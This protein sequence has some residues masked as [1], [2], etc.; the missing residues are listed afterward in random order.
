MSL[1]YRLVA[2]VE[3]FGARQYREKLRDADPYIQK[4]L[5]DKAEA[6]RL[7]DRARSPGAATGASFLTDYMRGQS[8]P[9]RSEDNE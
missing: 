5:A 4:R 3:G 7:L 1:V 6:E 8:P 9:H 2:W